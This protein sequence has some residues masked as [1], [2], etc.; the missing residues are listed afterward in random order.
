VPRGSTGGRPDETVR[1]VLVAFQDQRGNDPASAPRVACSAFPYSEVRLACT[2]PWSSARVS[3]LVEEASRW[4]C[5]AA[6]MAQVFAQIHY[7]RMLRNAWWRCPM[8][9]MCLCNAVRRTVVHGGVELDS[10][11]LSGVGAELADW[12][13][14]MGGFGC[15]WADGDVEVTWLC[16]RAGFKL[17]ARALPPTPAHDGCEQWLA[18]A[19]RLLDGRVSRALSVARSVGGVL[20]CLCVRPQTGWPGSLSLVDCD[21]GDVQLQFAHACLARLR[22]GAG[23]GGTQLLEVFRAWV[24]WEAGGLRPAGC[25]LDARTV[26]WMVIG[27][28]LSM[29]A[30]FPPLELSGAIRN[31]QEAEELWLEVAHLFPE[32]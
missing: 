31:W 21:V 24:E 4:E 12:T 22:M 17:L 25:C 5:C 15:E 1:S 6:G 3:R 26:R 32:C 23:W 2:E 30:A 14:G 19:G 20:R 16:T 10:I 13:E 27:E 8:S 9:F 18:R 11:G 29:G 28:A 7:T